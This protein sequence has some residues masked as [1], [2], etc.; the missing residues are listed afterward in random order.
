MTR[1]T[2]SSPH[3]MQPQL[4]CA[5]SRGAG[6][7]ASNCQFRRPAVIIALVRF[8][9]YEFEHVC[10]VE[11]LRETD[12]T[13]RQHMPQGRYK[14]ARD[15]PL[16]LNKYG[17]GPFCKFRI[18]SRFPPAS[19]LHSTQIDDHEPRGDSHWKSSAAQPEFDQHRL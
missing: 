10:D 13:L 17:A 7:S 19:E 3:K 15:L 1:V 6:D 16:N 5:A 11:P 12:G 14:N 4:R 9:D 2:H 18:P 8:A